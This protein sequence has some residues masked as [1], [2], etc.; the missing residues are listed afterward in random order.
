MEPTQRW[1]PILEISTWLPHAEHF[2]VKPDSFDRAMA[3]E[4]CGPGAVFL[5]R[6]L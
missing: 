3:G 4:A 1:S 5:V 2:I 6:A